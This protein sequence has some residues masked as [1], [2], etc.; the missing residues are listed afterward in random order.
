MRRFGCSERNALRIV[1]VWASTCGYFSSK[2]DESVLKLRIKCIGSTRVHC[3]Y[4]RVHV[5]LRR[6]GTTTSSACAG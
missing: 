2:R 1:G 3:G 5:M 6:E 4:R